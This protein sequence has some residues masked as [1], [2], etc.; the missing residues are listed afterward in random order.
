MATDEQNVYITGAAGGLADWAKEGTQSAIAQSL[1]QIQADNNQMLRFLHKIANGEKTSATHLSKLG[2]EIKQTRQTTATA[3][4][5]AGARDTK[6]ASTNRG[7][8]ES[9]R[10]T[11][12]ALVGLRTDTQNQARSAQKREATYRDLLSQGFSESAANSGANIGDK[13][14]KHGK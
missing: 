2:A 8:I 12:S 10:A 11:L 7:I 6:K 3:A 14:S 13:L 4:D 1:K 9:S 5:Q